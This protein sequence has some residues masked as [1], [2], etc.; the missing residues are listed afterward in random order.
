MHFVDDVDKLTGENPHKSQFIT[1]G[2]FKYLNKFSLV[3]AYSIFKIKKK[4]NISFRD[5][6]KNLVLQYLQLLQKDEFSSLK[7]MEKKLL[8]SSKNQTIESYSQVHYFMLL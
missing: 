8:K 7:D 4:S 2:F 1:T 6:Q 5:F 3:D